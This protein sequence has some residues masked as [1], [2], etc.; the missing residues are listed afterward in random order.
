[1]S[2]HKQ[3]T[4]IEE[5]RLANRSV[6]TCVWRAHKGGKNYKDAKVVQ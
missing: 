2:S 1:L 6:M 4:L 3:K 5:E